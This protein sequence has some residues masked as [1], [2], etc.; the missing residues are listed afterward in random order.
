M[1]PVSFITENGFSLL[2]EFLFKGITY[3]EYTHVF[4]LLIKYKA[5]GL[6]LTQNYSFR[7]GAPPAFVLQLYFSTKEA[8]SSTNGNTALVEYLPA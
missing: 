4:S 2:P 3:P 6:F 1:K 8:F 7:P 5:L